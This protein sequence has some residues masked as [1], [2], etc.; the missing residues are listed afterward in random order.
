MCKVDR[1]ERAVSAN[2]EGDVWLT[3]RNSSSIQ[4][5]T[6]GIP[7]RNSL[8]H[9]EGECVWQRANASCF[10][11]AN[12]VGTCLEGVQIDTIR[13]VRYT[14]LSQK[15]V[16]VSTVP[17]TTTRTPQSCVFFNTTLLHQNEVF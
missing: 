16:R 9:Y 6:V 3:W 12:D 4:G 11:V 13:D 1:T 17:T 10:T 5:S 7:M 2:T 8:R 14:V 15:F